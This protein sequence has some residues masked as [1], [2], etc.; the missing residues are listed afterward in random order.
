MNTLFYGQRCRWHIF[1][2][3]TGT[4]PKTSGHVSQGGV[5]THPEVMRECTMCAMLYKILLPPRCIS[6]KYKSTP[7]VQSCIKS[8]YLLNAS[9]RTSCMHLEV[10]QECTMGAM[11]YKILLPPT[12]IP[13]H[14]FNI[15]Q[16][17][18]C[19]TTMVI[20]PIIIY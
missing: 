3:S 10:V 16:N 12:H 17:F 15:F 14:L 19:M 1:R 7:W 2:G 9:Q 20:K 4:H 13:R 18:I 11:L 8:Y 6:R 5:D